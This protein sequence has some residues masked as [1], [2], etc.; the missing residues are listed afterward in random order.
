MTRLLL[1]FLAVLLSI[2]ARP[3][4]VDASRKTSPPKPATAST[5][6]A[7]PAK[8]APAKSAKSDTAIDQKLRERLSRSKINAN[9]FTFKVQNGTVIWEGKTDVIQHKGAATRMAKSV[10]ARNV[11]NN[12]QISEAARQKAAARL[13]KGRKKGAIKKAQIVA[14]S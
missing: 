13:E 8:A 1:L 9:H 7:A 10:G 11:V 2:L 4:S 6:K 3:A 14:K 5:P 12:I